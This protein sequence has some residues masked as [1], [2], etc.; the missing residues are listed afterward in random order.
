[1]DTSRPQ[2]NADDLGQIKCL[3]GAALALLASWTVVFMEVSAW[4]LV[5]AVNLAVIAILIR[6]R[7]PA[8]IPRWGHGMVFPAI[9]II[10]G[11]D[12]YASGEP[13]ASLVRLDLMLILYRVS[14]FR[15]RRD[16][17]QLIVL[18]LFMIVVAGVLTVSLAFTLQIVVFTGFALAF[19]LAVTLSDAAAGGSDSGAA[20][21]SR[22]PAIPA[23]TRA[24]WRDLA[25]RLRAATDWRLVVFGGGL[26]TAVV[27]LSGLLF[28]AIPRF[29]LNNNLFIDKLIN[30]SVRTGFSERVQFGE[31]TD[32]AQDNGLAL[33]IDVSDR[34]AMP[35][36]PY[37]RMVVLDD[38]T[39][40]GFAMSPSLKVAL[41]PVNT[42]PRTRENGIAPFRRD[43]ASWTFFFESGVSR[44]LPLLGNYYALNFTEPQQ[45]VFNPR[46]QVIALQTEPAKMFAY[47]VYGMETGDTLRDASFALARRDGTGGEGKVDFLRL[48]EFSP[49]DR[50][51]L[52]R[53]VDEI[54]RAPPARDFVPRAMAWLQRKHAY[55]LQ[56]ELPPGDGDP[57]VRW[58][59]AEGPGHCEFFAG[60]LVVLARFAGYPA[61]LVTGFRG[62]AWN[63]YS[64]SF[65]VRNANAHA[66]CEIFD[67]A[68]AAWL[69]ADPTP[70]GGA[71][72]RDADRDQLRNQGLLPPE[73]GWQARVESLRVFWYRRIVNFDQDTQVEL[74]DAT[75]SVLKTQSARAIRWVD[76][77]IARLRAWL[78]S[79]WGGTR[80]LNLLAVAAGLTVVFWGWRT[81][82]KSWW[83]RWRSAHAISPDHDPVRRQAGR[84]LQRL[85]RLPP[86][87]AFPATT[88]DALLRLRYGDRESWSD[89][90]ATL[91]RAKAD[92]RTHRRS[93]VAEASPARPTSPS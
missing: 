59:S 20:G 25:R 90:A 52:T 85:K 30:R 40:T 82:G 16:D 2:L 39:D 76:R 22:A 71:F 15:R 84:W 80:W 43:Q 12:L 91:R 60:S 23:W 11:Y 70:G 65:A 53:F 24:R 72:G 41:N 56:S 89:P 17:L 45:F 67:D 7:W 14:T 33:Q 44:Y 58:M 69:R 49:P 13:L 29:E 57:L 66:W 78:Q 9:V 19:L 50:A 62:G 81:A 28:L 38:Y 32:I 75:K 63:G 74:I 73:T 8:L 10:F 92:F 34:D 1:M 55:S 6:P 48:P 18:C 64:G 86:G 46:L 31:V 79:P 26:F 68:S 36:D 47:Q 83:L 88:R 93:P 77:R 54:G 3:C 42:P 87:H 35:R 51:R 27:V 5:L 61:R 37:W 4:S 21:K